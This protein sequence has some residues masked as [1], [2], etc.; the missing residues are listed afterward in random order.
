MLYPSTGSSQK[1]MTTVFKS[2]FFTKVTEKCKKNALPLLLSLYLP[3]HLHWKL[4]IIMFFLV[5]KQLHGRDLQVFPWNLPLGFPTKMYIYGLYYVF[6]PAF[7]TRF[8]NRYLL[9]RA[10]C[11]KYS[12]VLLIWSPPTY[13]LRHHTPKYTISHIFW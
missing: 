13:S 8:D 1:I 3:L 6:I 7:L 9:L 2:L 4:M 11:P 12:N 5:L 10:I